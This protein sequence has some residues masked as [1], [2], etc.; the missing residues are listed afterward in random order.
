MLRLEASIYM[1]MLP[2][3]CIGEST[4]Q[5]LSELL[6]S[7]RSLVISGLANETAK[8]MIVCHLLTMR[9]MPTVI[10]TENEER[11]EGMMHWLSFF[12]GDPFHVAFSDEPT[13]LNVSSV[14]RLMEGRGIAVMDKQTWETE[15]PSFTELQDEVVTLSIGSSVDFTEL[16]SSLIDA[17]YQHTDDTHLSPGE[18][19]RIG[20]TLDIFPMGY[21]YPCKIIFAFG[22]VEDIR[23]GDDVPGEK[24]SSMKIFS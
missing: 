7:K 11:V 1:S 4:H 21:N 24:L 8:A 22:V 3:I 13:A 16:F 18:Y 2:S 5:E 10:V 9:N 6:R 15:L 23:I 19:R 14:I 17:G 20:D 12:G